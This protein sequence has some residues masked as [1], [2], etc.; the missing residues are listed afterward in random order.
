M[1]GGASW[2]PIKDIPSLEGS[3]NETS[4][5]QSIKITC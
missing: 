1:D 4:I 3:N 2:Q 5:K